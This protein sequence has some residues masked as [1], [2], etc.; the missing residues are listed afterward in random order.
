MENIN[1]KLINSSINADQIKKE[2]IKAIAKRCLEDKWFIDSTKHI[3]NPCMFCIQ[4]APKNNNTNIT[5]L[6][7]D[8][9]INDPSQYSDCEVCLVDHILCD[10]RFDKNIYHNKSLIDVIEEER[11]SVF[12]NT[13][14]AE[15]NKTKYNIKIMIDAMIELSIFGCIS[16]HTRHV[17]ESLILNCSFD[18]EDEM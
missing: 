5:D 13:M 6:E 16:V 11:I 3:G 10:N 15:D 12:I 9:Y 7:Y 14:Y 2:K 17:I 4:S 8:V 18:R 1:K